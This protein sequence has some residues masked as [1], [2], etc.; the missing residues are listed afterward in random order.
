MHF[1]ENFRMPFKHQRILFHVPFSTSKSMTTLHLLH[2]LNHPHHES[3][4]RQC[5][6]CESI[7]TNHPRFGNGL[8]V[9]SD[10]A[11]PMLQWRSSSSHQVCPL[12]ATHH[13]P[14]QQVLLPLTLICKKCPTSDPPG[15]ASKGRKP[16]NSSSMDSPQPALPWENNQPWSK[17]LQLVPLVYL[18]PFYCLG[19]NFPPFPSDVYLDEV[20]SQNFSLKIDM[21]PMQH[22]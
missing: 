8:V 12:D 13:H 20:S 7:T 17:H 19:H 18:L 22:L 5:Q 3:R 6:H 15:S 4:N 11:H 21:S 9:T 16:A 10:I 1:K 2:H 14:T